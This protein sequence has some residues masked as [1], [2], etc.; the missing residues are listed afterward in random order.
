MQT[1]K[2]KLTS[3]K[4]LLAVA[5]AAVNLYFIVTGK[6]VD[7]ELVIA[8]TGIIAAWITGETALD[9]KAL[10]ING[11]FAKRLAAAQLSAIWQQIDAETEVEDTTTELPAP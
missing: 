10:E 3:R 7:P 6:A 8:F 4:F 2:Q 5:T 1:L 9:R 11:D